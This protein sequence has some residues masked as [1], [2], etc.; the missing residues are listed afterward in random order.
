M[1][2]SVH[3]YTKGQVIDISGEKRKNVR[4]LMNGCVA[5]YEPTNKTSLANCSSM[6]KTN[7]NT[8]VSDHN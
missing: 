5:I 4:I 2:S 1:Y 6:H 3:Y 7:R 8:H